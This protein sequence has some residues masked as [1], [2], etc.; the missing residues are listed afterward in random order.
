MAEKEPFLTWRENPQHAR[1]PR[2]IDGVDPSH[3]VN[4]ASNAAANMRSPRIHTIRLCVFIVNAL[5]P[6]IENQ[7][8]DKDQEYEV[9]YR[10]NRIKRYLLRQ[11]A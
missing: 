11:R 3:P 2:Q 7:T 9:V 5:F 8:P 10:N 1:K 4:R 6:A